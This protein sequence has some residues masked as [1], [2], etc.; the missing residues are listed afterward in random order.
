MPSAATTAAAATGTA[1]TAPSDADGSSDTS[2]EL[3]DAELAA[4]IALS[5]RQPAGGSGRAEPQQVGAQTLRAWLRGLGLEH[6]HGVLVEEG[7]GDLETMKL[8]EPADLAGRAINSNDL[9]RLL[10]AIGALQGR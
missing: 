10:A 5:Q 6:C 1:D 3:S 7:Y 4:A 9:Q 8:L 2:D